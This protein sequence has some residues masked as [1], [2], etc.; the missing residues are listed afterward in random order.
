MPRPLSAVATLLFPL[1]T[2]AQCGFTYEFTQT[3]NC[4]LIGFDIT[5]AVS[6][7]TA[8]YDIT[9]YAQGAPVGMG[10]SIPIWA[11]PG[12]PMVYVVATDAMG[13]TQQSPEYWIIPGDPVTADPIVQP[14][15]LD[16][17]NNIITLNALNV[18]PGC[19]GVIVALGSPLNEIG[20]TTGPTIVL[21]GMPSGLNELLLV[22]TGACGHCPTWLNVNVPGTCGANTIAGSVYVDVDNSC[23]FNAG[24]LPAPGV[25][26][27]AMGP[28]SQSVV[29]AGNGSYTAHLI[30]G[31][32]DLELPGL[33]AIWA[34]D[35]P[36][37]AGQ[38]VVVPPHA[39]AMDFG[40]VAVGTHDDLEVTI[41]GLG[42]HRTGMATQL[43]ITCRNLGNTTLAG[44]VSLLYDPSLAY[45]GAAPVATTQVA[46]NATWDLAA[47]PP[48]GSTTV[49][50]TLEVPIS[51]VLGS[52]LTYT[53]SVA[54][55]PTDADPTNNTV[56]L[57][58]IVTGSFDPNDKQV[59]PGGD[60]A[61]GSV[62]AG[63][64]L[65]YL[66]RFQN[67]GN[68]VAID[69]RIED[70]I[71]PLLDLATFEVL[72]YSHPMTTVVTERSA[73]F[74]FAGIN[75]PDSG[76]NFAGS[77]GHVR[78]RIAP[79]P[80]VLVN[81]VITNQAEIFFD[82]N[83]PIITNA[84]ATVITDISTAITG[85]AVANVQVLRD[86][87]RVILRSTVPFMT[88]ELLDPMGRL[89]QQVDG[90]GR[91]EVELSLR[92]HSTAVYLVRVLTRAGRSVVRLAR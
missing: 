8:P 14:D 47:L 76:A 73:V 41:G 3:G 16:C 60:L 85:D 13:C 70:E 38:Q 51:A 2:T 91:N 19:G 17:S 57:D 49:L 90:L 48:F 18:G 24:D 89:L 25:L 4:F 9:W 52:T 65:E 50:V 30:N 79:G 56:G 35:C 87:D 23:T 7:G 6:G 55:V 63:A 15:P 12:A 69:V 71:D 27:R 5:V 11:V 80:G 37:N 68:D 32:Y 31:A 42:P 83:L 22:P 44:T 1:L 54:T 43:A 36:P 78:Y 33:G 10:G 81:D 86:G 74:R 88:V 39:S 61:I 58:R 46:G 20:S 26:V 67:T 59:F 53:A 75:L 62:V 40:L 34:V 21:T 77:Q 29:S 82:H 45:V 66:V 72:G 84:V 92:D 64:A 28:Q